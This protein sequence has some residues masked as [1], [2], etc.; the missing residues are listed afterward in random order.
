MTLWSPAASRSA[1][2]CR[3]PKTWCLPTPASRWRPRRLPAIT[4]R[5]A[6]RARTSSGASSGGTWA[7]SRAGR[8]EDLGSMS[9]HALHGLL[10]AAAVRER[11]H[12][13]LDLAVAGGVDGWVVDLGRLDDAA[14]L[15]AAVTRSS[16][17]DLAI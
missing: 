7:N 3:S 15:T 11:A 13:M 10:N 17:P 12:E 6:R 1:S 14:A 4:R 16:Y 8:A 9:S 5:K 2:A